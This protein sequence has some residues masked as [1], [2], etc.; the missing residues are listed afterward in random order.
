[1]S[2]KLWNLEDLRNSLPKGSKELADM[3]IMIATEANQRHNEEMLKKDI[4]ISKLKGKL[5]VYEK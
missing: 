4:E 2:Y 3:T 5:E 1:M